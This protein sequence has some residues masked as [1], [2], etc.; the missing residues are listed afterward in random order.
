[1]ALVLT[2]AMPSPVSSIWSLSN[3]FNNYKLANG[4]WSNN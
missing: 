3:R 4:H 2:T 1:V